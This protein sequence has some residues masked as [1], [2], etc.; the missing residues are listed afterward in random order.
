MSAIAAVILEG[1][2]QLAVPFLKKLLNDKLGGVGGDLADQA[3][4]IVAG[5]LGAPAER[6][7]EIARQEPDRLEEAI[8]AAEP[9]TADL[10]LAH[11]ESQRFANELQLA[12]MATEQTWSWAWRPA[13]M[14]FLGFLWFW[15]LVL[16]PATDAAIGSTMAAAID[17]ATLAWLTT[18]FAG[19]YMGGHTIKAGLK[20]WAERK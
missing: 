8:M 9:A 20:T 3:I 11:V 15:R 12:E 2:A 5:K 19:F 16:V 6:I 4:D 7:P 10:L 13:W 18:L 14:W 17:L 1:A